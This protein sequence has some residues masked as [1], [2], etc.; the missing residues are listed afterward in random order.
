MCIN[1]LGKRE[2]QNYE[3][4]VGVFDPEG[5]LV[6]VYLG[7]NQ[8]HAAKFAASRDG[9]FVKHLHLTMNDPF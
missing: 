5:K 2:V 6:K 1:G 3:W 8:N 7:K 4:V 9:Y